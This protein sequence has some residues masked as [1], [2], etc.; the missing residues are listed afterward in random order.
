MIDVWSSWG[1]FWLP[2]GH[3]RRSK[4]RLMAG[5]DFPL[6]WLWSINCPQDLPRRL[7][8]HPRPPQEPPGRPKMANID[9]SRRPETTKKHVNNHNRD[10]KQTTRTIHEQQQHTQTTTTTTPNP[11]MRQRGRCNPVSPLLSAGSKLPNDQRTQGP[12]K[13]SQDKTFFHL[14]F[15]YLS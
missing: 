3:P 15:P 12:P 7:Q 10:E 2:L 5:R 14:T 1:A 13:A 4:N 8:D 6:C 9:L 11:P